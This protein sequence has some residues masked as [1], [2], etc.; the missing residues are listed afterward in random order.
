MKLAPE[1]N[2]LLGELMSKGAIVM[3]VVGDRGGG[4]TT[5]MRRIAH[6]L[7]GDYYVTAVV[8]NREGEDI[9]REIVRA[10]SLIHPLQKVV[11][12]SMS[13]MRFAD[14]RKP[15]IVLVEHAIERSSNDSSQS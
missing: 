8:L 3:H 13:G 5:A 4:K 7:S 14:S 9:G 15:W 11:E 1:T 12:P 2:H 10:N 6:R